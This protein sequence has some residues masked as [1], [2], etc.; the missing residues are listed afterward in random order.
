MPEVG[1]GVTS[2]E[3][4]TAAKTVATIG[5]DVAAGS[6]TSGGV[7]MEED[8]SNSDIADKAI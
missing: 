8:I 5:H 7:L 6:G 2:L 4:F 3:G 1:A